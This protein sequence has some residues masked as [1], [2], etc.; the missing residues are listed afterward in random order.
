MII[1]RALANRG[2]GQNHCAFAGSVAPA[3]CGITDLNVVGT[4]AFH[5]VPVRQ[6]R[7]LLQLTITRNQFFSDAIHHVV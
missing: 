4:E 6:W 5:S 7:N 2:G 3:A 1:D